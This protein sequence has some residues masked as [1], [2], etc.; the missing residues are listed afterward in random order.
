MMLFFLSLSEMI[1]HAS[2]H[3]AG[4]IAVRHPRDRK[5][6][7]GE[8]DKEIFDLG[9]PVR[10]KPDLGAEARGPAGSGVV[11]RETEGLAI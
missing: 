8:V 7:L 3:H 9:A 2:T 5:R 4:A 6:T 11:F 10:C 1:V